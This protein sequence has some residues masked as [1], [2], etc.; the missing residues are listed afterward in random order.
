[1][2]R[3]EVE[4]NV[5][6]RLLEWITGRQPRLFR[7][8]YHSD[9]ALD[10]AQNAQVIA[11][12]SALGYLTLGQD[13]DPEDFAQRDADVIAQRVLAQVDKGSVIL[14]HD[15]GGDRSATLAAL[16][17][18]LDGLAARGITLATPEE[19]TGFTRDQLLPPAPRAPASALIASADSV[20][21]GVLGGIARTLGPLFA[22][23]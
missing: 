8:P 15:G 23:A 13:I 10:E 3:M 7:P 11:R 2:L 16:P 4:L 21:F 6:E 9:E 22:L 18:I 5:N 12:A 17:M 1:P 20:V 19:M 14:L